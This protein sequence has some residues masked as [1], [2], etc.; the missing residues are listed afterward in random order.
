MFE[1]VV[2]LESVW[3]VALETN[4]GLNHTVN[5]ARLLFVFDE[6]ICIIHSD[7][8]SRPTEISAMD[9]KGDSY[10][11]LPSGSLPRLSTAFEAPVEMMTFCSGLSNYD[12]SV[13]V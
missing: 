10:F 8:S 7:D 12:A 2:R 6:G 3:K 4:Y 5:I 11:R 13:C 9:S 1:T